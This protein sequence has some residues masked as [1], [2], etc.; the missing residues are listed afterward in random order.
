MLE[1]VFEYIMR[2]GTELE[3]A[4]AET[5]YTASVLGGVLKE[6]AELRAEVEQLTERLQY[7]E[8]SLRIFDDGEVSEYFMRYP[9]AA[10]QNTKR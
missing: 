4:Q 8:I 1:K 9:E 3:K 5:E 7:A 2:G 6:N 10:A